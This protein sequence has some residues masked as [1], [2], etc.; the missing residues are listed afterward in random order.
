MS[1]RL[2]RFAGAAVGASGLLLGLVGVSATAAAASASG[3]G[4]G[5]LVPGQ[6][7]FAADF[8]AAPNQFYLN[9]KMNGLDPALCDD[10]ASVLGLKPVWSN[11]TFD[12]LIPGLQAHRFDA[13]CTAVFI[14][15]AREQV[16]N[17]VPYVKW[18]DAMSVPKADAA[19]YACTVV[20]G[21]YTPCFE[22]LA[23]LTIATTAGGVEQPQ[24]VAENS[25]LTAAGKKPMKILAFDGNTQ[26]YEAIEDGD[27]G[28]EWENDP[29]LHYFDTVQEHGA[30]V[31]EFSGYQADELSLTTNKADLP[32]AKA[33]QS[34]LEKLRADGKYQSIMKSWGVEPVSSFA[35]NPPASS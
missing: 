31:E 23:G 16:M 15:K 4:L 35:I 17:M 34:G 12:A 24:L 1:H 20:H 28:A 3:S 8:T 2:K 19:K 9:G 18:G 30:Y 13:L 10:I 21:N 29:Q 27:A 11:L 32:L 7:H 5:L 33:L 26:A 22:K 14:T 6:I 25:I